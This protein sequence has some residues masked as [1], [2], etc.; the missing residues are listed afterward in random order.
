MRTEGSNK[1]FINQKH[2]YCAQNTR[3]IKFVFSVTTD[4]EVALEMPGKYTKCN[5]NSVLR[6]VD[7]QIA[8]SQVYY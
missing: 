8:G 7:T 3:R 5:D 1:A 2:C 6:L 4:A